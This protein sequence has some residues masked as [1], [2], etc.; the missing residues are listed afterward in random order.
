MHRLFIIQEAMPT[1]K[2][3]RR[4]ASAFDPKCSVYA[5]LFKWAA[6][7]ALEVVFLDEHEDSQSFELS[8]SMPCNAKRLTCKSKLLQI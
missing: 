4:G 8:Y 2:A 7:H 5:F 6:A 1:D 3:P